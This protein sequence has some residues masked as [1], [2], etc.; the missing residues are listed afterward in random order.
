MLMAPLDER[1]NDARRRLET[2]AAQFSGSP[3]CHTTA[4]V[5]VGRPADSIASVAQERRAGL[6]VAGLSGH[7]RCSGVPARFDRVSRVACR[8]LCLA[9]VP[10][11]VVP[12][13]RAT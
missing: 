1:S 7:H 10:V 5:V 6:I 11:L 9:Q 13:Q 3:G 4:I 12:T 8:V 2:L